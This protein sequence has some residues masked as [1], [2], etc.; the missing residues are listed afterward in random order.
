M[1]NMAAISI[2]SKSDKS[3]GVRVNLNMLCFEKKVKFDKLS[4]AD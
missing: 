1:R 3:H 4:G 2:F